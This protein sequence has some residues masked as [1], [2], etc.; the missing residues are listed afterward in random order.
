[1]EAENQAIGLF[2]IAFTFPNKTL[3]I[4]F[5]LKQQFQ[6]IAER[7]FLDLQLQQRNK[8]WLGVRFV[9]RRPAPN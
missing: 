9:E 6:E 7:I 4:Q 5:K 3:G 8:G 1:M 2:L